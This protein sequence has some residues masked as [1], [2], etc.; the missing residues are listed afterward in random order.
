MVRTFKNKI[1]KSFPSLTG[2]YRKFVF[3]YAIV[4]VPL[5][6]LLEKDKFHWIEEAQSVFHKLK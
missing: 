3:W 5:A 2:Y 4:V 1:I 6:S